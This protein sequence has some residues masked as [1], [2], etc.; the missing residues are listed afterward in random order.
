MYINI[1][2]ARKQV[3]RSSTS[4]STHLSFHLRTNIFIFIFSFEI[5]VLSFLSIATLTLRY[6]TEGKHLMPLNSFT[7]SPV[8]ISDF[9]LFNLR[10]HLT[11]CEVNLLIIYSTV[12]SLLDITTM[13]SAKAWRSHLD[14]TSSSFFDDLIASSKYTLNKTGDCIDP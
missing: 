5:L 3:R 12:G 8:K 7:F 4:P 13:S 2:L 1:D 14:L 9:R 6:F 11:W 10:F